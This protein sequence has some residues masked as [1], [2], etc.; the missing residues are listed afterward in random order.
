MGG[1]EILTLIR[2]HPVI[3]FFVAS[4]AVSWTFWAPLIVFP[5]WTGA[6]ENIASILGGFGPLIAA[7]LVTAAVEGRTGVHDLVRRI[8]AWRQKPI[9]YLLALFLPIVAYLLAVA[10]YWAFNERPGLVQEAPPFAA[11]PLV[12]LFAAVLGGGLEEPGWR[13]FAL[14]RL[15]ERHSPLV[16]SLVIGMV[17]GMWHIPLSFADS[18]VQGVVAPGWYLLNA[19]ALSVIFTWLF[20]RT[21]GSVF[22][23]ILL[24]ASVNAPSAWMPQVMVESFGYVTAGTWVVAIV[25]VSATGLRE[26]VARPRGSSLVGRRSIH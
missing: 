14:P 25:V 24:H 11:Y 3:T 26:F 23:A 15:Q 1:S 4:C 10:L 18:T 22:L 12:L 21:G 2:R 17:W 7:L 6:E 20:N 13:G 5:E 9:G 19:L 8:V 16:S